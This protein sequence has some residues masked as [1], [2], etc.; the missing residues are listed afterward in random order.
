[1]W[2]SP[3]A[4]CPVLI[5]G[6]L[7]G[8]TNMPVQSTAPHF[9]KGVPGFRVSLSLSPW[10]LS[11]RKAVV[12]EPGGDASPAPLGHLVTVG[13]CSRPSPRRWSPATD[14]PAIFLRVRARQGGCITFPAGCQFSAHFL[15]GAFPWLF[16]HISGHFCLCSCQIHLQNPM[17]LQFTRHVI[18][19]AF[20]FVLLSCMVPYGF[21]FFF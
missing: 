11:A 6:A 2:A 13:T 16:S 15:S 20:K 4:R 9:F 5:P 10:A 18:C 7:G 14:S 17:S 19:A 12:W 8:S 21:F 3:D 1:M